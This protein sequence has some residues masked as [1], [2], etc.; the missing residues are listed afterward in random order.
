MR[1]GTAR[2]QMLHRDPD[3]WSDSQ[4]VPLCRQCQ[5]SQFALLLFHIMGMCG[6]IDG[7][8]ESTFSLKPLVE[9]IL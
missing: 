8:I 6:K 3:G 4:P 7:E 9:N 1:T 2:S 5:A